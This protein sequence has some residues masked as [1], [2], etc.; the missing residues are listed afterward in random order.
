MAKSKQKVNNSRAA[1]R[2]ASPSVD[3]DKSLASLPRVESSTV[4]RTSLLIDRS[5]SGIQKKKKDNK[6]MTKAQRQRQMKGMERAEA[7]MD[8]LETK[9]AKSLNRAKTIH[10]RRADWADMNKKSSAILALHQNGELEENDED[11]DAEE[12]DDAMTTEAIEP[13]NPLMGSIFAPQPGTAVASTTAVAA[14][15]TT[16]QTIV[17]SSTA[18]EPAPADEFDEIT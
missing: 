5:N 3:L 16:T 14:P 2:G 15:T 7:V 9:K 13:S 4:Q 17:A 8:Q 11:D 6:R 12:V 18:A 10:E 1:R